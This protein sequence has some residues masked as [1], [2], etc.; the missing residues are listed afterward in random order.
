MPRAILPVNEINQ[1]NILSYEKEDD[2]FVDGDDFHDGNS[3]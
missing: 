2:I 1:P 3:Y